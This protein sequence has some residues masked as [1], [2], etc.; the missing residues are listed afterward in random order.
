MDAKRRNVVEQIHIR[1]CGQGSFYY[2]GIGQENTYPYWSSQ[3]T[4]S[5]RY[6]YGK[7]PC[8]VE[9][10]TIRGASIGSTRTMI[11]NGTS[12]RSATGGSSTGKEMGYVLGTWST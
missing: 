2:C 6:I 4:I 9:T 11:G 10:G 3:D 12:Y 1:K 5:F 8:W 7:C